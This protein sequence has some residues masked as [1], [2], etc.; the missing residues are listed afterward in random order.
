MRVLGSAPRVADA[1]AH[2][3]RRGAEQR[4]VGPEAAHPEGGLLGWD[5]NIMEEGSLKYIV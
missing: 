5:V 1:R 2:D 4:V 3:T